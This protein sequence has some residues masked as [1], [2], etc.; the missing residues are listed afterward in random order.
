MDCLLSMQATG[1]DA[2]LTAAVDPNYTAP[3]TTDQS[4]N[5]QLQFPWWFGYTPAPTLSP[6][7]PPPPT[8]PPAAGIPPA[9]PYTVSVMLHYS[10]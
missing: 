4:T 9:G 5:I 1:L 7:P 8:A 3:S 6:P 2:Q 10:L